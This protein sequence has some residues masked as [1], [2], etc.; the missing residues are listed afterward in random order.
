MISPSKESGGLELRIGCFQY[1]PTRALFDGS[2]RIEGVE[3]RFEGAGIVYRGFCE[4]KE[5]ALEHY[6]RGQREP[7]SNVMIPG[8]M[9]LF[10]KN[11]DL[12][13]DDWLPYGLAAIRKTVD[14]FLRYSFEQGLTK[15]RLTCEDIF[16]P[17]LLDT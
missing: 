9:P 5:V 11:R 17:E 4:A 10:D 7:H 6:R 12:F 8:F 2:V 1:D 13:P 15:R 14:T 3:A 16:V